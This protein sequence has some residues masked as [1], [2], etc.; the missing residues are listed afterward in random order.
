MN[1][2]IAIAALVTIVLAAYGASA[3]PYDNSGFPNNYG[4]TQSSARK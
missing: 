4:H 2:I 3:S 1:K